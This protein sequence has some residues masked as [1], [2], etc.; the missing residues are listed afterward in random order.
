M[1]A[2]AI[3]AVQISQYIAKQYSQT[4]RS[5]DISRT[6]WIVVE[7]STTHAHVF[8]PQLSGHGRDIKFKLGFRRCPSVPLPLY[9]GISSPYGAYS[10]SL[11]ELSPIAF[12]DLPEDAFLPRQQYLSPTESCVRSLTSFRL[13][14]I[15]NVFSVNN[16]YTSTDFSGFNWTT[17]KLNTEDP[18]P[19]PVVELK[20][21]RFS[22]CT[23]DDSSLVS[24]PLTH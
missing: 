3:H 10:A 16:N 5:W 9:N 15:L 13:W 1:A 23:V 4:S 2:P 14:T 11:I 19:L 6:F 20:F 21:D 17:T 8:L 12:V 18:C 7:F 22:N 24:N